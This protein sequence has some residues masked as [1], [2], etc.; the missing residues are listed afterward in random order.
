MVAFEPSFGNFVGL[1]SLFLAF[2]CEQGLELQGVETS[3]TIFFFLLVL[4][5]RLIQAFQRNFVHNLFVL[6]LIL[7]PNN[8]VE[9]QITTSSNAQLSIK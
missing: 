3:G 2:T 9:S 7:F 8:H 1:L 5:Y 4:L 6:I